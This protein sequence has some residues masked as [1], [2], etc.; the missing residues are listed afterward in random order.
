MGLLSRRLGLWRDN[1]YPQE[2]FRMILETWWWSR[3]RTRPDDQ[4]FADANAGS[5]VNRTTLS[6]PVFP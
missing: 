6:A 2:L 1:A 3:V 5:N 4:G